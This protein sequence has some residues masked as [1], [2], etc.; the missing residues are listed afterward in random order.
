[1]GSSDDPE[2][3]YKINFQG[4]NE[5]S[6]FAFAVTPFK[7]GNLAVKLDKVRLFQKL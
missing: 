6:K 4:K 3:F 1:M 5:E 7:D 2:P